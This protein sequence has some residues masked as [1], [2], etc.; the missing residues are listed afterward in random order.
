MAQQ[1]RHRKNGNS[2]SLLLRENPNKEKGTGR[3]TRA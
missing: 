3:L 2:T 1:G